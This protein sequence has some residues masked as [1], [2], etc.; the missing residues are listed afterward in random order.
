[1]KQAQ[2]KMS[3]GMIFSI[4]LII[5]FLGFAF[6]AI[7]LFLGTQKTI[8]IGQFV[9]GLQKDV[10]DMWR[11]QQ[12]NTALTKNKLPSAIE[13]I[14]FIDFSKKANT[15]KEIYGELERYS[16]TGENLFLYPLKNARGLG[17]NQVNHL[18]IER[19]TQNK[20]PLCFEN[21]EG[22]INLQIKIDFGDSLVYIE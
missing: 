8:Q 7:N 20:N 12:G 6:Y 14:C 17:R 2:I 5:I 1:M 22:K 4:I 15:E 13:K 9:D 3:F 11:S 21:K 19:T 10:E 18:D 16:E